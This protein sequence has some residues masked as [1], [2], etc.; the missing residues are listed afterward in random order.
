MINSIMEKNNLDAV[1]V[2]DPYNM[3]KLS[4]F[5]GGE[6]FVYISGKKSVIITDS[7]YIEAAEKEMN[8]GFELIMCDVNRTQS[9]ILK[10]LAER[11][12][13][14]AIGYEDRHLTVAQFNDLK[15]KCGFNNLVPLK[16]SLTEL[17]IIKTEEEIE[18]LRI[19]ESIGDKAFEH[20]L[21]IIR[22]GMTELE[23]AAEIEYAMKLNG[24]ASLSF[25]TIV[26]SGPNSSLPHAVPGNRV[27]SEGDFV[28]MDFGC[29]YDGYCSDMTRT[30]VMGSASDKQIEIYNTVL[31]AQ[32]E[33]MKVIKSGVPGR[34]VHMAALD[35]I[36]KAGYGDCFGH[37]LGHSVGMYIHESPRFSLGEKE[38]IYAGTIETVE[39]G[40]YIP[41]FGGVRIEDM[42]VVTEDGF[43]NLTK[44][45]KDLLEIK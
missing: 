11:D 15:I 24:A 12:G 42:I 1:I 44:S 14:G 6:G 23:V 39:P 8:E 29:K 25:D 30:V 37:G 38:K 9:A 45:P 7:R 36:E 27:I 4:G 20:V 3:R 21:N 2:S 32:L 43:E 31:K 41:G 5:S 19:A 16:N 10:E 22:V 26:A 28:L 34:E 13:A 33:A 18:K 17:R 35:V 40:I